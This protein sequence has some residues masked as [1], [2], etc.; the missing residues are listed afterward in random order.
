MSATLKAAAIRLAIKAIAA[1][2]EEAR[3]RRVESFTQTRNGRTEYWFG[4]NLVAS[5]PESRPDILLQRIGRAARRPHRASSSR[6][7][8][9]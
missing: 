5:A 2:I 3:A 8:A 9:R 6:R 1:L 4:G 7:P